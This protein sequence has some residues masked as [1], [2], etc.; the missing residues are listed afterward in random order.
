MEAVVDSAYKT[1]RIQFDDINFDH[2]VKEETMNSR[3]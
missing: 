2:S 3:G 1:E